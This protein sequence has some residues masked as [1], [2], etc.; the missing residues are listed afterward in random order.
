MAQDEG[1]A[2]SFSAGA[3][4]AGG[5]VRQRGC[6]TPALRRRRPQQRRAAALRLL[7]PPEWGEDH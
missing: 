3:V 7:E 5:A 6:G 4:H 1:E 2:R